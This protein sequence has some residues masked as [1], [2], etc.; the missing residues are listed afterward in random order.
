MLGLTGVYEAGVPVVSGAWKLEGYCLPGAPIFQVL[1]WQGWV[2]NGGPLPLIWGED[3]D[4]C[5]RFHL[6]VVR[7]T[8]GSLWR[9]F[10]LALGEIRSLTFW[11]CPCLSCWHRLGGSLGW[12]S[13]FSSAEEQ[14]RESLMGLLGFLELEVTMGYLLESHHS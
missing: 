7:G 6:S 11:V 12:G 2:M 8:E 1:G 14:L 13:Q 3:W 4:N 5:L 9:S 10:F